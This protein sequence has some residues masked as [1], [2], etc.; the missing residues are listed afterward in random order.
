MLVVVNALLWVDE[1]PEL[2]GIELRYTPNTAETAMIGITTKV[3]N[4]TFGKRPFVT[5]KCRDYGLWTIS[6]LSIPALFCE[7]E[8]LGALRPEAMIEG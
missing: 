4:F 7:I 6:F 8:Q 1:L 3:I 2:E 5:P